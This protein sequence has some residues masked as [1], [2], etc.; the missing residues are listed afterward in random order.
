[1]NK[2]SKITGLSNK[3][4]LLL[5][6]PILIIPLFFTIYFIYHTFVKELSSTIYLD[7]ESLVQSNIS[8]IEKDLNAGIKSVDLIKGLDPLFNKQIKIG[9]TGFIFCIDTKGNMI[10]HKKAQGEN[11]SYEPYIQHIMKEKNGFYRYLSPKTNTYKLAAFRQISGTDLIIVASAFEDDFLLEPTQKIFNAVIIILIF[12]ILVGIVYSIVIVK[13]II[14]NPLNAIVSKT[15]NLTQNMDLSPSFKKL[16]TSSYEISTLSNGLNTFIEKLNQLVSSIKSATN[17]TISHKDTM[18]IEIEALIS[19]IK[20]ISNLIS[21]Q[22]NVFNKIYNLVQI[23]SNGNKNTMSSTENINNVINKNNTILEKTS[24]GIND[25]LVKIKDMSSFSKEQVEIVN[26]LTQKSQEGF[27]LINETSDLAIN[28]YNSV[29]EIKEVINVI[30]SI[31][32]Q[33]NLLAMNAAIEAAH[34]GD[35]GR[36][37]AVVADEI[38]KLAI[39]SDTNSKRISSIISGVIQNII[40]NNNLSK[41]SVEIFSVINKWSESITTSV[42]STVENITQIESTG[43][44]IIEYVETLNNLSKELRDKGNEI[45]NNTSDVSNIISDIS[46]L[47][48]QLKLQLDEILD[49]TETM[50]NKLSTISSTLNHVSNSANG[51]DETLSIFKL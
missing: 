49:S 40:T 8:Y 43:N 6:L 29:E 5:A 11:W 51:I 18:I 20:Y 19:S 31:S 23:S 10:I 47:D 25:I 33:T 27:Q 48:N 9:K 21:E 32:E 28:I 46:S 17:N 36:G 41:E 42:V 34:A 45:S 26:N 16:N 44:S 1:M 37:F 30:S 39:S 35:A 22:K 12:F 4:I 2:K 14:S 38:R 24:N 50:N 13:K 3:V 7:L 15:N